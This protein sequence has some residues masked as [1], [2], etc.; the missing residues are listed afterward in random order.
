MI[1]ALDSNK[2]FPVDSQVRNKEQGIRSIMNK[3]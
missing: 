3:E 1:S 2:E